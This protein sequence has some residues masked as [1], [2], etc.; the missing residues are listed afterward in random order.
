V[1]GRAI[2]GASVTRAWAVR[3]TGHGRV[4]L[5]SWERAPVLLQERMRA[6]GDLTAAS[7]RLLEQLLSVCV[8]PHQ[9]SCLPPRLT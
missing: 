5:T 7:A 6:W 8:W 9:L 4:V 1:T 2:R 3:G